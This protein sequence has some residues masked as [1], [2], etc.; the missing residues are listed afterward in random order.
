MHSRGRYQHHGLVAPIT[1]P[2]ASCLE[3]CS[4][5]GQ[6]YPF[7]QFPTPHPTG[8][9]SDLGI[10]SWVLSVCKGHLWDI[11]VTQ[12]DSKI[13]SLPW[14]DTESD[15]SPHE[16]TNNLQSVAKSVF[17]TRIVQLL[18]F[19]NPKFPA[20]SHL[21]CLYTCTALFVSDL[22]E[23]HIHL[24]VFLR[25]GSNVYLEMYAKL[26]FCDW[27]QQ[28]TRNWLQARLSVYPPQNYL[29]LANNFL[30][31]TCRKF[32]KDIFSAL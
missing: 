26:S 14:N 23:N 6:H 29:K 22:L 12:S 9:T 16:K 19:L 21:L 20:S 5:L 18:Y 13:F 2:R 31:Q 24:L 4:V 8:T 11:K 28:I 3:S 27:Q 1:T 10:I 30:S 32:V 7:E 25:G 15:E 17:T